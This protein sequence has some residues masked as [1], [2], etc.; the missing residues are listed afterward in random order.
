MADKSKFSDLIE[1]RRR[2]ILGD[3]LVTAS[4]LWLQVG[5]V[6]SSNVETICPDQT[7]ASAAKIM[8]ENNISCLV[9]ADKTKVTGIIT[10]TDFLKRAGIGKNN[11]DKVKVAD[12][13]SSPVESIPPNFSILE[14]SRIAIDKHIKRLPILKRDGQLV[15]IV[16]QTDMIRSL[17][18][19]G[20]W[21]NV[22]DIMNSD[23][24]VIDHKA[25]VADAAKIMTNR[26]ISCIVVLQ[27]NQIAGIFT[28]RDLV[29]KV[30]AQRKDPTRTKIED[31]MSSPAINVPSDCSVFSA[32]RIMDK[33]NI[34][35]LL[36]MDDKRLCGIVTQTDIFLAMRNKLEAE[37]EKNI[38]ILIIDD[39]LADMKILQHHL[40]CCR[41]G[42]VKSEHALNL[43]QALE[44]LNCRHF[45]LV[46][47]NNKPGDGKTAGDVLKNLHKEKMDIP[48][49]IITDQGN[50]QTAVELMKMGAYD[51][52]TKDKFTP[53]LIEKTI[54]TT[55]G[56]YT[57]KTLQRYSEQILRQSEERYR[58]LITAV[59]DYIYTVNFIDNQPAKTA[60]S[61]TSV[62][63]TGYTPAEFA[64]DPYL[65]INMVYC[66]DR[67]KVY[68]QVSRCISGQNV[69]PLEHRILCKN[70][71]M[72]WIKST[73]VPHF[74]IHG[75]ILSYD[76]LLQDITE[77]KKTQEKLD[78]KQKNLEAIFDA[79]P[80]GMLLVDKHLTV[81]RV[82]NV[83]KNMAFKEYR[84]IV[85]QQICNV[86]S[87]V[88]STDNNKGRDSG[89]A[90]ENCLLQK[91]IEK[92]FILEQSV[93][94]VE[95]C[96]QLTTENKGKQIWFEMGAELTIIDDI[97]QVVISINDVTRRVQSEEELK[98]AKERIEKA[99]EKLEQVNRQLKASVKRANLLAQEATVADLAKSQFLANMSHE[100]RT[101]MN[102]IIGFSEVLAEGKLTNE[103]KHHIDIIRESAENLLQ[104]I[105]DILDVSKVEAGRL[106]I[107]IVD[108]S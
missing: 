80:V 89:T 96:L 39:D 11:F 34:R 67:Q 22:S 4:R 45:D 65:W 70:G 76:G 78:H 51:Y 20:M 13:M 105:N 6:M 59:T 77:R 10:E 18:S 40:N 92:V 30:T 17:T 24:A 94:G 86:L 28:E 103:Q 2:E 42:A 62:A 5:D 15:G 25:T 85:N 19:Y 55:A 9:V 31:V 23:V 61:S 60:H 98:Q 3:R 64:A 84:D 95:F 37:E 27:A 71:V 73:L 104:L 56:Q 32:N 97:P 88:N 47:L 14:A 21:W 79:A 54:R 87:C 72:R 90:C 1:A 57:L 81:K 102:A 83:I 43:G 66:D 53:E 58:R 68:E 50:Q 101:P 26:N 16:T 108:C 33:M 48:V 91:T 74:D 69:G 44:K 99:H 82:N 35:R 7:I 38:H 8:T 100:I 29:K 49:I 46:F 106:D 107:E 63:V 12:I 93:R 75:N 36:C 52:I 41:N